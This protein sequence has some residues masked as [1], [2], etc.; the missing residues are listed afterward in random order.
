[1]PERPLSDRDHAPDIG[2]C[3]RDSGVAAQKELVRP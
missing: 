1:M 3:A 2:L